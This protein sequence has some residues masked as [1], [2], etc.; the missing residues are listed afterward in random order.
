MKPAIPPIPHDLYSEIY[1]LAAFSFPLITRPRQTGTKERLFKVLHSMEPGAIYEL[2]EALREHARAFIHDANGAVISGENWI[3]QT[4]SH[5]AEQVESHI[6]LNLH[7][8]GH[9]A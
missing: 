1:I 8:K 5:L 2:P 4:A 7:K 6:R 9:A 3:N